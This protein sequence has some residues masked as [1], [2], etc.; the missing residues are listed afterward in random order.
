MEEQAQQ[1]AKVA[2]QVA[3]LKAM[4]AATLTQANQVDH[5]YAAALTSAAAADSSR[6]PPNS[7]QP[8][9]THDSRDR[10]SAGRAGSR[11]GR[12]TAGRSKS[13]DGDKPDNKGQGLHAPVEGE[14]ADMPGVRPWQ[15]PGDSKNEG[16][17]DHGR[18]PPTAKD[19]AVHAAASAAADACALM[20]PDA[21]KNLQHY[22]GNT[23]DPQPIDVNGMMR[24]LPE[25]RDSSQAAV[26]G[27][28]EEAMEDA[29][30][31]GATGPLTYPFDTEWQSQYATKEQDPNWFYATG[32]YQS[33]TDGTITVYP[34][35]ADNPNWSY[36]YKYRVHVADRYNWDGSKSTSIFG[37][38]ITD[39]QLQELHASGLA[40]EYDL[41]GESSVRSGP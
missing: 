7:N 11:S 21:A 26:D 27:M 23:G 6:N 36:Q 39:K 34:P 14:Q 38:Q 25:L 19:Y 37:M 17:G 32:G 41:S 13:K 9:R 8:S 16:S 31:R 1:A 22:L 15:Y 18:R 3:E 28:A 4:V 29:K 24:D 10:S 33:A 35:T 40:K 30:K 2:G 20:W 12:S 5:A